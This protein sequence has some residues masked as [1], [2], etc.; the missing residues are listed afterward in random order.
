MRLA[1]QFRVVKRVSVLFELCFDL[2]DVAVSN[3]LDWPRRSLFLRL[4]LPSRNLLY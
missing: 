1:V 3:F 2:A 4:K